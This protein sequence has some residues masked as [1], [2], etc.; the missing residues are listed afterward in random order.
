MKTGASE[1]EIQVEGVNVVLRGAFNPPLVSPGWLLANQL[2]SVE[3]HETSTTEAILPQLASFLTG[4]LR[5]NV[6]PDSFAVE[7]ETQTDFERVRDV[8]VGILK[9]LPHTPINMLGINHYFH[10]AMPSR[11]AWHRVGDQ[12]APK[13]A[14][15]RLLVLPGMQ[16]V[17]IK[18]IRTDRFGGIINA[19]VQPSV[20]ALPHGIFVQQNDHFLLKYSNWRPA[21]R[22]DFGDPRNADE[23]KVPEAS[24]ELIEMAR[25]IL[26]EEWN[27]SAAR[28][29]EIL[30]LVWNVGTSAR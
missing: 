4:P 18:S 9:L 19:T 2:I 25:S 23:D 26:L 28:A 13:D 21:T 10:A 14:W 6:T 1:P 12:L 30:R 27:N 22:D 17:T 11:E 24:A 20:R 3:E 5:F 29:E 7:T 8:L 16:D 15:E